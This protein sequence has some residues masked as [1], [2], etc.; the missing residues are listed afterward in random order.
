MAQ[1]ISFTIMVDDGDCDKIANVDM[2]VDPDYEGKIDTDDLLRC[3][4]DVVRDRMK[5]FN[6]QFTDVTVIW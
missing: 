3:A 4:V 1:V 6:A 5:Q 2:T